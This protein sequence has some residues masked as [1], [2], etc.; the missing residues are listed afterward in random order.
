MYQATAAEAAKLHPQLQE[1]RMLGCARLLFCVSASKLDR[2]NVS[3]G[4]SNGRH[5]HFFASELGLGVSCF[6]SRT[7][8]G[9]L[10]ATNITAAVTSPTVIPSHQ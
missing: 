4:R 3:D 9:K 5:I 7:S 10:S 6:S 2:E 8:S 1:P